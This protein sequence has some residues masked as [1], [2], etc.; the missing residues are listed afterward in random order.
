MKDGLNIMKFDKELDVPHFSTKKQQSKASFNEKALNA[1][2]YVFLTLSA[3]MIAW[4][5]I[6]LLWC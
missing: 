5:M 3:I 1:V 6:Q 4:C 2:S